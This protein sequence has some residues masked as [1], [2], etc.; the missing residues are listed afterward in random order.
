MS[1][2]APKA[3][4]SIARAHCKTGN[5]DVVHCF[6]YVRKKTAAMMHILA[7]A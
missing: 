4:Q 3:V 7:A 5:N 2:G 1:T 6:A